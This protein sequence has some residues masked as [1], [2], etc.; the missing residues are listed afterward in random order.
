MEIR[1]TA[2][3]DADFLAVIQRL[4]AV[5]SELNG[6]QDGFYQQ[7]NKVDPT[8]TVVVGYHEG[9]PVASGAFRPMDERK[10]EVKRMFV[11][12]DL[13][14]KGFA[15]A[16]LKEL[17]TWA[18]EEGY[19]QAVL[20]TSKRLVPAVTLYQSQGY[21]QT[22]NYPPYEDVEDSVCFAKSLDQA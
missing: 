8:A 19:K 12:P 7:F 10:V 5:L 22:P 6:E 11:D 9:K 14:G 3:D 2:G 16:I 13:R 18:R 1:R 21:Q 17:E 15:K 20:E 4:T